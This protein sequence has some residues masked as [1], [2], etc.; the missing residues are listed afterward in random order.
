M[1]TQQ[2]VFQG[3]GTVGWVRLIACAIL[4]Y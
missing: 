4:L 3:L 1:L 2:P